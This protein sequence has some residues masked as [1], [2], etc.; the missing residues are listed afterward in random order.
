MTKAIVVDDTQT[1][2]V[3]EVE[4]RVIV[5]GV[6]GPVAGSTLSSLRDVEIDSTSLTAESSLVYDPAIG[7]WTAVTGSPQ[8]ATSFEDLEDID[9]SGIASGSLLVYNSTTGKWTATATL[10]KQTLDC[11]QF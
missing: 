3:Q 8:G 5:T 2:L 6:M 10:D 9:L 7:K 1:I 4:S 11:G